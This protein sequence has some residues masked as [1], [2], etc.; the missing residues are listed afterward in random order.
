MVI[1]HILSELCVSWGSSFGTKAIVL[2]FI[3]PAVVRVV[4]AAFAPYRVRPF[5]FV[6]LLSY[7]RY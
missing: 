4:S 6:L 7:F 3:Q 5:E 1:K 2:A